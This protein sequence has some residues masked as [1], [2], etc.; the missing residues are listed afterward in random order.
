MDENKNNAKMSINKYFGPIWIRIKEANDNT[1]NDVE[2]IN[3]YN[4]EKK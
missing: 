4:P 1:V 3:K 2:E